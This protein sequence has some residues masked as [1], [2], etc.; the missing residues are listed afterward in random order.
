[1]QETAGNNKK[2]VRV[3]V[4]PKVFIGLSGGVDSAVSAALLCEAGFD[5]EALFIRISLPGYPCTVTEDR[6]EALR[7]AVHL[8]IPFREIDL[9]RE[10]RKK[11]F[12]VMLDSYSRGETP[13][14][15]TLCNRDI[16]FGLAY[17]YARGH[18]ADFFATGHYAR[19][20]LRD[21]EVYL[22]A[23]R[24]SEKDQS[25]FL[26]DVRSECFKHAL[27]PV[28]GMT[29]KEVRAVAVKLHL[30]NAA[31][32]DSQGV[33]FLGD[34]S[35]EE[36]LR[37]EL[38]LTPGAVLN[39]KGERIGEHSGAI[40]YTLGQR[41]GFRV[42]ATKPYSTPYIVIAK[43]AQANTITVAP[44]PHGLLKKNPGDRP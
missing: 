14:P 11:V 31:R 22:L 34:L 3:S 20:I 26:A 16:K 28:G 17:D 23:G 29:K 40:A 12:D 19:T 18:G 6:R 13:N 9:S 25:Y 38:T 24:D 1:M 41:H 21:E 42:F 32:R 27:F 10:Y 5:V 4:R 7:V 36:T 15:D 30:P 2:K 35:M 33:C 44:T 37:R 8:K 43:N 39:T